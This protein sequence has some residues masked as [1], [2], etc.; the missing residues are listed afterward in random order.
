MGKRRWAKRWLKPQVTKRK[1]GVHLACLTG[2]EKRRVVAL[3]KTRGSKGVE[4]VEAKREKL[5]LAMNVA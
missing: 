1:K 2:Q 3:A 5:G 4:E